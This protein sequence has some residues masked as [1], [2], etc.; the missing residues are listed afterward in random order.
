[1]N[2]TDPQEL[3]QLMEDVEKERTRLQGW[4]P[5]FTTGNH[6]ELFTFRCQRLA[7]IR[8]NLRMLAESYEEQ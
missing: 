6:R 3:R 2:L 4:I 8:E 5:S 1:M 7:K